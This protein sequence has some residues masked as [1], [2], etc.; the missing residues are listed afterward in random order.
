MNR[1]FPAGYEFLNTPGR[2]LKHFNI[3]TLKGMLFE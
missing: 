1:D 2:L 3:E